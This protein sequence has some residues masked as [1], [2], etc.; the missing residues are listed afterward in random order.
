MLL[1]TPFCALS[2]SLSLSH[3]LIYFLMLSINF[4]HDCLM[5]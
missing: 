1:L 3:T 5:Q 4:K 2:L